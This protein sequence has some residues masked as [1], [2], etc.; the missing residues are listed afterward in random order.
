MEAGAIEVGKQ[1]NLNVEVYS[2]VKGKQGKMPE[3][4]FVLQ[5]FAQK[6]AFQENYS[7][8]TYRVLFY[9]FS[10]S[11]YENFVSIDIKTIAEDL[12]ISE[13]SVKRATKQLVEHNVIIKV[14]HPTDKRRLDYFLNPHASWKGK[15]INRDKFLDKA[16]KD[17]MQ[18]DMFEGI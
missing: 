18:L 16:K 11:Q 6:L 12:R 1:Q 2:Y 8:H 5:A 13:Q 14:P 4:V 17:R 15:T 7:N 9:F 3:S 10:L